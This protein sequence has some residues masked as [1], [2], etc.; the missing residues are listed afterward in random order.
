MFFPPKS[1]FLPGFPGFW[2]MLIYSTPRGWLPARIFKLKYSPISNFVGAGSITDFYS[3]SKDFHLPPQWTIIEKIFFRNIFRKFSK[4]STN[5][6]INVFY[7]NWIYNS[8]VTSLP[9][10]CS[11]QILYL[12]EWLRLNPDDWHKFLINL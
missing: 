5:I 6:I 4:I 11:Q 12:P 9:F 10:A 3:F 7:K 1:L 8:R 2:E